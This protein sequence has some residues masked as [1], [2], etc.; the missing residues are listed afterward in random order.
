MITNQLQTGLGRSKERSPGRLIGIPD[1]FRHERQEDLPAPSIRKATGQGIEQEEERRLPSR[2]HRYVLPSEVPAKLAPEERRQRIPKSF[3]PVRALV[4]AQHALE[5]PSR[6][7]DLFHA[8][9]PHRIDLR[10][11]SGLS[12]PQHAHAL[13]P[14]RQSFSQIFHQLPDSASGAQTLAEF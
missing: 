13:S 4:V 6:G 11:M 1:V 10:D 5:L 2:R 9:A 8:Q 7:H 3:V 14:G 12:S